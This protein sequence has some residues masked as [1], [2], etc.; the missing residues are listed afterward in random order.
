MNSLNSLK[1]F[2]GYVNVVIYGKLTIINQILWSPY[3]YRSVFM[4]TLLL[5]ISFYGNLTI[6]NQFLW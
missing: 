3:Y 1:M 6:I 4:V 2:H 5:L